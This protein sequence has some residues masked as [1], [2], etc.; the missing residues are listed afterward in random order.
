MTAG[1]LYHYTLAACTPSVP[2]GFL[3]VLN[4]KALGNQIYAFSANETTGVLTPLPGFP[5]A[6]GG[7][8]S[9]A[10]RSVNSWHS[11]RSTKGFMPS[12][13]VRHGECVLDRFHDRCAHANAV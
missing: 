6:T 11:T 3:Y 1:Q 12:T 7:N 2:T 10:D 4:H 9:G 8:G 5:L 13:S